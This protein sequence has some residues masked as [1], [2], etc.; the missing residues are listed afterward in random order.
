MPACL[1]P[2]VLAPG[3]DLIDAP[4]PFTKRRQTAGSHAA[5]PKG[6]MAASISLRSTRTRRVPLRYPVSRPSAIICRMVRSVTLRYSAASA[7][8]T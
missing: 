5:P 8:L 4:C 2:K 6:R 7:I 1:M 3:V